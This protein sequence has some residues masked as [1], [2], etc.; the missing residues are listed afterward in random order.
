M[1]TRLGK[2]DYV[3]LALSMVSGELSHSPRCP[4]TSCRVDG[5]LG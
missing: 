2:H 5:F 3:L 4:T 1:T